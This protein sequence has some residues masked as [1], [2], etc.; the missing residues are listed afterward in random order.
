M[1]AVASVNVMLLPA[2]TDGSLSGGELVGVSELS[3]LPT[4][5]V[6]EVVGAEHGETAV[7]PRLRADLDR[8][9]EQAV[10]DVHTSW[11]PG[12]CDGED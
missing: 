9:L 2:Q 12:E 10:H 8:L 6:V 4:L 5:E 7:S 1:P 3:G 11:L